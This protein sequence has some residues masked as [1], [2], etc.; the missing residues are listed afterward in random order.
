M[1]SLP[2]IAWAGEPVPVQ[3][4]NRLESGWNWIDGMWHYVE[5]GTGTCMEHPPVNA[6]N[7]P[8]LIENVMIRE[9]LY[10]NEDNE[11]EYRVIYDTKDT[12]SL[13][14]GWQEKPDVFRNLNL[15]EMD[16]KNGTIRSL[17]TREQYQ[18]Y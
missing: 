8:Y 9:G 18:I 16:K 5:E 11:I 13:T 6:E 14:V 1:L 10:Q 12:I 7:A 3:E 4:V 15:F 17:V 2:Q